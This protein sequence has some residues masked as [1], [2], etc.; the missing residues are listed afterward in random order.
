MAKQCWTQLSDLYKMPDKNELL[1]RNALLWTGWHKWQG[2]LPP[3]T[4]SKLIHFQLFYYKHWCYEHC[5]WQS[6]NSTKCW[7]LFI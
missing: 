6:N 2:Y 5:N 1:L 3:T 4:Y 7:I